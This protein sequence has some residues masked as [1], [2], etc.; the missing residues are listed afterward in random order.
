MVFLK[1][2][3][4]FGVFE[5]IFSSFP[6]FTQFIY[7]LY[8]FHL[9]SWTKPLILL[10]V[11]NSWS[12]RKT[13]HINYL[14]VYAADISHAAESRLAFIYLQINWIVVVTVVAWPII[15]KLFSSFTQ[16]RLWNGKKRKKY[17][18]YFSLT[19]SKYS[20][21]AANT[22]AHNIQQK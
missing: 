15:S 7:Q 22:R 3:H 8:H 11:T 21:L 20:T 1:N 17:M 5:V 18:E 19:S 13:D 12:H 4:L 14:A 6:I 10:N 2:V 9:I 16:F